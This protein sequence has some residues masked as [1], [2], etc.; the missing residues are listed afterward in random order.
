VINDPTEDTVFIVLELLSRPV[1]DMGLRDTLERLPE[2]TA[3]GYFVQLMSAV[4]YLHTV[5]VVHRDIKPSNL[6]LCQAERQVREAA[7]Q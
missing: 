7:I 1:M 3:R 5:G 2:E 6:L 4:E